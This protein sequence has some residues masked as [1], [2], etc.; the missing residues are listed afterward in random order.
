MLEIV[1]YIGKTE[2]LIWLQRPGPCIFELTWTTAIG[3]REL[4]TDELF[5]PEVGGVDSERGS[6]GGV[7]KKPSS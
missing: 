4:V 7:D 5:V 3:E 2:R 6:N 1:T